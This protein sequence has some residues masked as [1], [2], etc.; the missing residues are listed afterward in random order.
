MVHLINKSMATSGLYNFNFNK[1]PPEDMKNGNPEVELHK[2][3]DKTQMTIF[4]IKIELI[5]EKINLLHL[6]KDELNFEVR[7]GQELIKEAETQNINFTDQIENTVDENPF[8]CDLCGIIFS[9][10]SVSRSA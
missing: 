9:F 6:K 1:A 8:K 3:K 10:S 5:D 4:N 2:Q 7:D